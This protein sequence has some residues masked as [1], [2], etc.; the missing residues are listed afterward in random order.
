MLLCRVRSVLQRVQGV[1]I[2]LEEVRMYATISLE[3]FEGRDRALF[4]LEKSK[5]SAC[6]GDDAAETIFGGL[7]ASCW[8]AK[9]EGLDKKYGFVRVFQK[10]KRDCTGANS[11]GSRGVRLTYLLPPGIYEVKEQ[12]SWKRSSRYFIMVANDGEVSDITKDEVVACLQK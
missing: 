5:V 12:H 7:P 3:V 6:F 1:D 4:K 2:E 8:V 9:I 10:G 11:V